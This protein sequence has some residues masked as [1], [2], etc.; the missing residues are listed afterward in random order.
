M[1]LLYDCN[2]DKEKLWKEERKCLFSV[3]SSKKVLNQLKTKDQQRARNGLI[4]F[5]STNQFA[6]I[7]LIKSVCHQSVS[8]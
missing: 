3:Q 8:Q 4:Q 2:Y 5:N 6:N 7:K 1:L